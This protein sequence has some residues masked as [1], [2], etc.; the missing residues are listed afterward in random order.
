VAEIVGIFPF[1]LLK[2]GN[3]VRGTV[4]LV[5]D[6]GQIGPRCREAGRQLDS[7]AKQI[8]GIPEPADAGG[9]FGHHADCL[10]ICRALFEIR[11]Q[12]RF[13]GL[14]VVG[15]QGLACAQQRRVV[16]R[17]SLR[18]VVLGNLAHQGKL[19]EGGEGGKRVAAVLMSA[20][21]GGRFMST[22]RPFT[23]LAA[24]IF[25]V[26]GLVHAYRLGTHFQIIVGSHSIG[27]GVSWLA[28]CVTLAM[29]WLLFREARR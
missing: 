13:R 27:L 2:L 16:A 6:R 23:L 17:Y 20:A 12:I 9:K 28:L 24:I 26:M 15:D 3:R 5:K 11:T 14:Q 19:G 8:L 10:H 25:L 4:L 18:Q 1:D 22:N 29:A 7:S 21:R